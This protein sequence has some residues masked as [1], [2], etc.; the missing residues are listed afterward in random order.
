[1]RG[2]KIQP[3]LSPSAGIESIELNLRERTIQFPDIPEH[4]GFQNPE[5]PELESP[6]LEEV[7]TFIKPLED[8]LSSHCGEKGSVSSISIS[9]DDLVNSEAHVSPWRGN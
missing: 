6:R 8:R 1:L 4:I 9:A 7:L 2:G 3:V 5:R